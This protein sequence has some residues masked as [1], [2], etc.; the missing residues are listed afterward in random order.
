M[1]KK[2]NFG[3]IVYCYREETEQVWSGMD[4]FGHDVSRIKLSGFIGEIES[5]KEDKKGDIFYGV[6]PRKINLHTGDI[7]ISRNNGLAKPIEIH[8]SNC[9]TSVRSL[10]A[11][12]YE[13]IAFVDTILSR[14]NKKK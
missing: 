9:Y 7:I 10:K 11:A 1:S 6:T 3:D 2:L 13:H 5:I 14:N 4:D 8:A 12:I